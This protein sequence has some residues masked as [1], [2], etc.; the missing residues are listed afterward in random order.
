MTNGSRDERVEEGKGLEFWPHNNTAAP[1]VCSSN[2]RLFKMP[3]CGI[4]I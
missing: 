1:P 2:R 3:A 4:S